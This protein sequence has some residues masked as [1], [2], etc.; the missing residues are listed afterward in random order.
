MNLNKFAFSCGDSRV[1]MKKHMLRMNLGGKSWIIKILAIVPIDSVHT[2]T[3]YWIKK[4]G[5]NG[6]INKNTLKIG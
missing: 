4:N 3:S 1:T 5:A 2:I 6:G